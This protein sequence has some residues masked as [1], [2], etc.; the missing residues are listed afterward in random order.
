MDQYNQQVRI[1]IVEDEK[2]IGISVKRGLEEEGFAVDLA[3]DGEDGFFMA[4][5]E[6]YDLIVL[7]LMLPKM[8]GMDICRK[9]RSR[10]NFTPILMLTARETLRDKVEGLDAGADDYLVKPFL[11]EELLA[12]IRSLIRRSNVKEPLL[13]LDNLE[14]NPATHIVTRKGQELNLTGK[15]Y[16]LLEYFMNHPRQVLSKEQILSHVWDY[17]YDSMSNTLEVLMKRLREK[18]DK[19]FPKDKKLFSTLRGLGYKLG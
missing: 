10:R 19:A 15:E 14:L 4:S 5:T 16:A 8:N 17:S 11:F 1:L 7:D 9:L 6:D 18:V 12:R 3:V 13:K 2:T